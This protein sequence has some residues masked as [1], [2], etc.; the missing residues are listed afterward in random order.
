M[1]AKKVKR[2]VTHDKLYMRV[3]GKTVHVAKGT[4]LS[5]TEEQAERLGKKVADAKKAASV[6]ADSKEESKEESKES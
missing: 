5:L 1:A 6:T 3:D 2:V 4:E